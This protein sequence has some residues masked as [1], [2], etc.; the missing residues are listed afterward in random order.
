MKRAAV[1]LDC[2]A[3]FMMTVLPVTS[4]ATVIPARIASGKF[5]GAITRPTPRGMYSCVLFSPGTRKVACG[6]L[7]C[8]ISA[9]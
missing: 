8:R 4:A 2:S 3:G 7:N 9:A 6:R 1:T 5:H